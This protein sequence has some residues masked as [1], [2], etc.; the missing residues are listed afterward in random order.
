MGAS[1]QV[2]VDL[3]FQGRLRKSDELVGAE[4]LLFTQLLEE[5]GP[6][7]LDVP[8]YCVTVPVSA[9]RTRKSDRIEILLK[10]VGVWTT[11][12]LEVRQPGIY[13]LYD[14]WRH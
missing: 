4:I 6:A 5:Q 14:R 10:I 3:A 13:V 1:C 9:S 11:L 12:W 7:L 2:F 8:G